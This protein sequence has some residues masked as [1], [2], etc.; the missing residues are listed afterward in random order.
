[1]AAL[2]R[3]AVIDVTAAG[4]PGVKAGCRTRGNHVK[5]LWRRAACP[6]LECAIPQG[7]TCSREFIC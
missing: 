7:V 2:S 4:Q 3:A 5:T 6:G 1:M